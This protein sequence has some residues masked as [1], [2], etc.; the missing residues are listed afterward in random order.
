MRAHLV[1][2]TERFWEAVQGGWVVHSAVVCGKN[3][4]DISSRPIFLV[5]ITLLVD[6]GAL[7][8]LSA[9]VPDFAEWSL[10]PPFFSESWESQQAYGS[11]RVGH[12]WKIRLYQGCDEKIYLLVENALLEIYYFRKCTTFT[13]V[14][15]GDVVPGSRQFLTYEVGAY[16]IQSC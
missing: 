2:Q 11:E 9:F 5:K 15:V 12:T 1:G 3:R 7:H 4:V 6:L 10:P 13:N 14:Q 16:L 8:L